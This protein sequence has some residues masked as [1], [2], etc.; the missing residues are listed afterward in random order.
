MTRVTMLGLTTLDIVHA[1]EQAVGAN[2]K[3]RA[4]QQFLSAGGPAANAAVVAAALGC[5]VH[6]ITAIGS[7]PLGEIARADL[8]AHGVR[9]HDVAK[10][11][12]TAPPLSPCPERS[13]RRNARPCPAAQAASAS[14][15]VPRMSDRKPWRNTIPGPGPALRSKASRR[16]CAVT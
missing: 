1:T 12:A 8:A 11:A 2:E 14:T 9:V 3:A 10:D 5:D 7:H 6:L 15:L 4:S 16:P 13:S